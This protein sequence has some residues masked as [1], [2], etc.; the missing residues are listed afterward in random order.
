MEPSINDGDW[1]IIRKFSHKM[2]INEDDIIVF[3]K[4][5]EIF[6]KRVATISSEK[7]INRYFVMGDNQDDSIDSRNFGTIN[8]EEIIGKPVFRYWPIN[9]VK[10]L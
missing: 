6:I 9:A 8:N 3:Y 5:N 2:Q 10:K 1:L 7:G 4:Q